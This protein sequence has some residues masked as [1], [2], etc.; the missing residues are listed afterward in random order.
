MADT[1]TR[2]CKVLIGSPGGNASKNAKNYRVSIPP[3]WAQE[4]GISEENREVELTFIGNAIVIRPKE[5]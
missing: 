1:E 4:L 3:K 5:D 2:T